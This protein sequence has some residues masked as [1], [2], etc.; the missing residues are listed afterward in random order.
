MT[1]DTTPTPSPDADE[2]NLASRL[3][4]D[5][6]QMGADPKRHVV[7]RA[8]AGSGKTKVL[9]D[10][11]LRLLIDGAPLKSVAAMTF[12]R[13]AAVEIRRRLTEEVVRFHVDD[14]GLEDLRRSLTKLLGRA[15]EDHHINRARRLV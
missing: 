3:A 1:R 9:V 15:P 11:L 12:T 8:S 5:I 4:G 13:K 6:Q 2:R 10:R 7:L 14:D